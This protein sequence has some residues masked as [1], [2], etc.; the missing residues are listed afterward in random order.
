MPFNSIGDLASRMMLS[1]SNLQAKRSIVRLSQELTTGI[2]SDLATR[3]RKDFSSQESWERSI[4]SSQVREKT[5]SEA[6]ARMQAKQ[7][8]LNSISENTSTLANNI[9]LAVTVGTT[10]GLDSMSQRAMD[11]LDEALS[12][13]NTQTAGQSLF[14]GSQKDGPAMASL[15][16]IMGSV[17]ASV[18]GSVTIE[19]ITNSVQNWMD[20]TVGGFQA[21]AYQGNEGESGA[22]RLDKGRVVHDSTR[23][24]DPAVKNTVQNLILASLATDQGLDLSRE[25]KIALLKHSSD[26]LRASDGQLINMRSAIGYV[27]GEITEGIVRAGAEISTAKLLRADTLQVDQ[28]ETATKLQEAE[29]QLEKIYMLTARS[30]QMSLLEYL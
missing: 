4:S 8:V 22:I 13:L 14:A 30:S 25:N 19:D 23:A 24:D 27:E 1:Q 3:L 12:R 11:T 10:T 16:V 5:L 28:Y 21:V 6:L 2:T 15:S 7:T 26:G 29:L 17:K 20:D 18:A 9:S